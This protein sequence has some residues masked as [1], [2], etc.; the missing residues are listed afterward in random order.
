M[1]KKTIASLLIMGTVFT[2]AAINAN[3]DTNISG[4]KENSDNT[5]SYT[6]STGI[7]SNK[8]FKEND[9]NWYYFNENGKMATGLVTVEGKKYYLNE[10]GEMLKGW[11]C[12]DGPWYFFDRETGAFVK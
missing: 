6:D 5:W 7:Y 1:I 9:G 8:W 2:A 12:V 11:V 4:W 10:S 3:A